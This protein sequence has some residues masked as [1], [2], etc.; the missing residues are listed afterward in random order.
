MAYR[1]DS[2]EYQSLLRVEAQIRKAKESL[3]RMESLAHELRYLL[4]GDAGEASQE[5]IQILCELGASTKEAKALVES[6]PPGL[7]TQQIIQE[8][9]K[10]KHEPN[11]GPVLHPEG[12]ADPPRHAVDNGAGSQP[13]EDNQC[14]PPEE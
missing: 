12:R 5:A 11:E 2:P 3:N 14:N 13:G 6:I 10:R 7:T 4:T 9:Y 1:E 8:V